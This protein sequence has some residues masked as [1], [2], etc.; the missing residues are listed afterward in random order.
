MWR[1][2]GESGSPARTKGSGSVF[3]G[4]YETLIKRGSCGQKDGG[5][6]VKHVGSLVD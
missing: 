5:K 4:R 6:D 1:R 2:G 3:V